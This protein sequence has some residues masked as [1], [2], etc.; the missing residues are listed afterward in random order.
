MKMGGLAGSP[1]CVTAKTGLNRN[2]HGG[3]SNYPILNED[4]IRWSDEESQAR[5]DLS[6]ILLKIKV[7]I[8]SPTS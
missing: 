5:L 7:S 2:Y 1:K 6:R 4:D 8:E 3:K